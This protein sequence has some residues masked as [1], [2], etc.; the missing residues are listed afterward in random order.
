MDRCNNNRIDC[1]SLKW[2]ACYAIISM[3]LL[4]GAAN[5]HDNIILKMFYRLWA[6]F[7]DRRPDWFRRIVQSSI[8]CA[9]L[10]ALIRMCVWAIVIFSPIFFLLPLYTADISGAELWSA[11]CTFCS[12]ASRL[13]QVRL[14]AFIIHSICCALLSSQC[15]FSF[16]VLC[17]LGAMLF[18]QNVCIY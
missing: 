18:A 7:H 12:Y 14:F 4:P 3:M 15:Q 1:E 8:V 6:R 9:R 5:V 11:F 17:V 10:R 16:S 2:I 13:W